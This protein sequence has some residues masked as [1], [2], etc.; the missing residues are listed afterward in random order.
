LSDRIVKAKK[1]KYASQPCSSDASKNSDD[2]EATDEWHEWNR[3]TKKF[4]C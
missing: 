3:K 2:E 1:S 4:K